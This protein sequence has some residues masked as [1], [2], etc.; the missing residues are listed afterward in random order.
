MACIFDFKKAFNRQSHEIIVTELSDLGVPGWLLL[1]VIAFLKN[2][3]MI[4]SYNGISSSE[5]SLP[6]YGPQGTGIALIL[7][8]VL[9]NELGFNGQLNN[10]GKQKSRGLTLRS[11]FTLSM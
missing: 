2:R 1:L 4:V 6:G 7:F 5:K 11:N 8:L 10:A 9:I 3:R